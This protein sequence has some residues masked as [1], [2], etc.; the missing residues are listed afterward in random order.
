[1]IQSPKKLFNPSPRGHSQYTESAG[2]VTNPPALVV[3]FSSFLSNRRVV[4]VEAADAL[5]HES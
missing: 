2:A 5:P 1:V 4:L 3:P